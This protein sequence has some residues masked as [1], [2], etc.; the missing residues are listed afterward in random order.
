MR[1]SS[2]RGS[3]STDAFGGDILEATEISESIVYSIRTAA[4]SAL[5][6]RLADRRLYYC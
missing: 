3:I 6:M 5:Q 4:A 1:K 2:E